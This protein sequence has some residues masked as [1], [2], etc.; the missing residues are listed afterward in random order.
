MRF[1]LPITALLLVICIPASVQAQTLTN[2]QILADIG[3]SSLTGSDLWAAAGD[4]VILQAELPS[5]LK[6]RLVSRLINSGRQISIDDGDGERIRMEWTTS[7]RLERIDRHTAG[8]VLEG[9]VSLYLISGDQTVLATEVVPFHYEDTVD[10][11][12][13]EMLAGNWTAERFRVVKMEKRPGLW[14]R[15][16]EPA[17]VIAATG[18]TVFLLYNVRSQ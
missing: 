16:A 2:G 9:S 6:A 4:R 11:D 10:A 7:N 13:A 3:A 18:V 1:R 12:G 8:R 14:R 15:I 17:V 5:P